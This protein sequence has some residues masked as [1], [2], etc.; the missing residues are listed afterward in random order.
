MGLAVVAGALALPAPRPALAQDSDSTG[1]LTTQTLLDDFIHFVLIRNDE[2]AESYANAIIKRGL[3]PI[4]F[5]GLVEDSP[6]AAQRFDDAIR[7]AMVVGPLEGVASELNNLFNQGRL[8]R[9]RDPNEIAR[10]IGFLDDNPRARMLARERIA[11]AR[12]YAVPQLLEVLIARP[13][14]V[15]EGHVRKLLVDMGPDAVAPLCAALDGV[16]AVTQEQLLVILGQIRHEAGGLPVAAPYVARLAKEAPTDTVRVEARREM[17]KWGVTASS[18]IDI[19]N[20][21]LSLARAYASNSRSLTRFPDEDYQLVWSYQ[22]QSGLVATGVRTEVFDEMQTMA[23]AETALGLN[24]D[25]DSALELWVAAN[26]SREIE[27]PEGWTNPLWGADRHN[28]DYYAVAAGPRVTQNVLDKALRDF[29]TP[30]ARRAIAALSESAGGAGLWQGLGDRKPLLD[31]LRYPDRRV[32]LE[33]ALALGG[34]NPSEAFPG[35]ERVTPILAG[36]VRNA[37]SRYGIVITRDADR[38]N[39]LGSVLRDA[40]FEPLQA[41]DSLNNAS[42]TIVSAPGVDMIIVEGSGDMFLNTVAEARS[43]SRLQAT[44]IV[45]VLPFTAYNEQI[46]RFEREPLVE[47][48]R[49]GITTQSIGSTV[50]ALAM[51]ALGA[52]VTQEEALGYAR[53]TLRTLHDIAVGGSAAYNIADAAQPLIA[54]L[55]ETSGE[56]RLLVADVLSRIRQTRAQVALMDAAM[57]AEGSERIALLDKVADSAKRYGDMLDERQVRWIVDLAGDGDGD[58]ATAAAA[59]I[60]SLNLP[61]N[62][63][64][65][66]ILSGE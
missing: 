44:P 50:K 4:E 41:A 24:P 58:E 45:A 6:R 51:K 52:P 31:A 17:N 18:D 63:L 39:E 47:L 14:P 42:S 60:G 55:D 34:A 15:L 22:P 61:E 25:S 53:A 20:L 57:N 1:E 56:I 32:Q 2:L 5:V 10:N 54:A 9:A 66:L 12:E 35:S 16:D 40:G 59:L 8:D 28:A 23:L 19:S 26:I 36:A 62:R 21:F 48:R 43:N 7:K 30:V 27:Q 46:P 29:N 65:P 38:A 37:G 13:N 11:F 3:S 33:A 64:V 49:E